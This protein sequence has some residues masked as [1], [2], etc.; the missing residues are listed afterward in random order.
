MTVQDTINELGLFV[1]SEF[2]PYSKSR[3]YA[4]GTRAIDKSLNWKVTLVYQGKNVLTTDYSAGIGHCP[5]YKCGRLTLADAERLEFEVE[6]GKTARGDHV[7]MGG[8]PILPNTADVI[9]SLVSDS[10]ALNYRDF[11]EWAQ[12][13]GYNTDSRKAESIYQACLK[14]G[15]ALRNVLGGANLAKLVEAFQDY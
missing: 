4:S 8:R 13:F 1:I 6:Q 12:S 5:S 2:V 3:K 9:Y 10:D 7:I 15:L 11:E 14:T